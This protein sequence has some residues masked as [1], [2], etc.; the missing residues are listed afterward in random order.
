[1]NTTIGHDNRDQLRR[2]LV[3]LEELDPADVTAADLDAAVIPAE[4]LG[5]SGW[6]M[7]RD[8]ELPYATYFGLHHRKRVLREL[9]SFAAF[10]ESA[11][12]DL[13]RVIEASVVAAI[14][15]VTEL[16]FVVLA[17]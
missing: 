16:V 10:E 6:Q 12:F 13:R 7:A 8:A 15:L 5:E 3:H 4:K 17:G 9:S 2:A 1:M 14:I 11:T